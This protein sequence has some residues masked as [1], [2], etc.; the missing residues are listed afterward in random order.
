MLP[1]YSA[2]KW[3]FNALSKFTVLGTVL[4]ILFYLLLTPALADEQPLYSDPKQDQERI[5]ITANELETDNEKN[6]AVFIGDVRAV[7][8]NTVITCQRLTIFYGDK[9]ISGGGAGAVE[10]VIATEAVKIIMEN[11]IG[12]ADKAEYSMNSGDIILTGEPAKV[13]TGNNSVAGK[14]IIINRNDNRM[15]VERGTSQRVEAVLY[16]E[17][18]KAE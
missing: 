18:N 7:Q 11:R 14:K 9:A 13:T 6:R 17:E 4:M 16:P 2:K 8:G 15:T 10:R 1:G 5:R 3:S 12:V